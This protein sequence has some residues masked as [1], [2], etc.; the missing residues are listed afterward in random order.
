MA[1]NELDGWTVVAVNET[2]GLNV[3]KLDLSVGYSEHSGATVDFSRGE[4][5][6]EK[7][8]YFSAPAQYLGRKMSSYGGR[9]NYTIYYAIGY[10]GK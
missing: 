3:T 2:D 1:V 5:V 10:D 4:G 8:V 7:T 9:L 6:A